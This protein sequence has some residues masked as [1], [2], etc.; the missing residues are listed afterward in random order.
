MTSVFDP[1][2]FLDATITEALVKRPPLPVQ[3]YTAVI[4]EVKARQWTSTKGEG[5]TGIAW[6]VP[7]TLEIPP[8]IQASLG[9]TQATITLKDSI[10]LDLTESGMIDLGLG[11]NNGLRKYREACDLNKPGEPFSARM[12]TGRVVLAK[13]GHELYNGEPVER[14][15]GVARKA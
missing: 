11:K 14:I 1:S 7:L 6:D 10:M 2:T 4:G 12:M 15:N 8:E 9:L 13:V 3:D 5:R